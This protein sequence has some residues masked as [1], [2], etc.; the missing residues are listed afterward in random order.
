MEEEPFKKISVYT[1]LIYVGLLLSALVVFSI[2]HRKKSISKLQHLK[3]LFPENLQKDIYLQLRDQDEPK[4]NDK[5][6]KAA[7]IRRG[8][9]AIRRML[10]LKE[11][12]QYINLLYQK[13]SIGDDVFERFKLASKMQQLEL[14]EISVEVESVKTGWSQTFFQVCQE[15]T[16]NEALRRRVKAV[17]ERREISVKEWGI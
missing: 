17:D 4:V 12:E 1:P 11:S 8:S 16:F 13:G 15:V 6:L 7:L 14:Q 5:V 2:A 3:P 10:K 9:E